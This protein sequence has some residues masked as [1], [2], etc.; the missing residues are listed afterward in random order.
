MAEL[1]KELRPATIELKCGILPYKFMSSMMWTTSQAIKGEK[2]SPDINSLAYTHNSMGEF[3]SEGALTTKNHPKTN[4]RLQLTD[5]TSKHQ[6]FWVEMH[7]QSSALCASLQLLIHDVTVYWEKLKSLQQQASSM[8]DEAKKFLDILSPED[9]Q[10]L[11]ENPTMIFLEQTT[12]IIVL[13]HRC[14]QSWASLGFPASLMHAPVTRK[15]IKDF[16]TVISRYRRIY[17]KVC[18]ASSSTPINPLEFIRALLIIDDSDLLSLP[19]RLRMNSKA[20]AERQETITIPGNDSHKLLQLRK[21]AGIPSHLN[22]PNPEESA[23]VK[24]TAPRP[25]LTGALCAFGVAQAIAQDQLLEPIDQK[26]PITLPVI[27]QVHAYLAKRHFSKLTIR[28][29]PGI[30]PNFSALIRLS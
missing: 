15:A 24:P 29:S 6:L 26:P 12:N 18:L 10:R 27:K 1:I 28:R 11:P 19:S 16:S 9:I 5:S 14:I 21:D 22:R 30:H 20:T 8:L 7:S 25:V 17:T 13:L 4:K 2:A 23:T 3:I